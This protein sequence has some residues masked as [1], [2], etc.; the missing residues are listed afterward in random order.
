MI[1]LDYQNLEEV[2]TM[3]ITFQNQLFIKATDIKDSYLSEINER[4]NSVPEKDSKDFIASYGIIYK[5]PDI[6]LLKIQ[7]NIMSLWQVNDCWVLDS[8]RSEIEKLCECQSNGKTI[9]VPLPEE[10]MNTYLKL[11]A[12]YMVKEE[13]EEE[14]YFKIT[15]SPEK[16]SD[17]NYDLQ[18][19]IRYQKFQNKMVKFSE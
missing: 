12:A 17:D 13:M 7:K 18:F 5:I 16:I 19:H 2:I 9:I 8:I 14:D 1:Y 11:L 6:N 3:E 15:A 10:E 4:V